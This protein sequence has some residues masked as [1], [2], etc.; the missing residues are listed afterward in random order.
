LN[1]A[2]PTQ[3]KSHML[4]HSTMASVISNYYHCHVSGIRVCVTVS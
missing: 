3:Q 4:L 2:V 1:L